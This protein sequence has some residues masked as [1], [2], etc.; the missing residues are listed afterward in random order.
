MLQVVLAIKVSVEKSAVVLM[1]FP[2]YVTCGFFFVCVCLFCLLLL[3]LEP[4]NSVYLMFW[5]NVAQGI[6]SLVLFIRCS[7]FFLCLCGRWFLSGW[8]FSYVPFKDL[9]YSIDLESFSFIHILKI[10]SSPDVPKLLHV[11]LCYFKISYSLLECSNSSSLSS[12]P[13]SLHHPLYSEHSPTEFSNWVTEIFNSIF[14]S[15]WILF[16]I[17]NFLLNLLNF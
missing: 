8:G 5:L 10:W 14:T 4:S 15:S 7:V 3:L 11:S 6:S 2:L 16:N 12:H 17:F 1:G 13:N 9:V